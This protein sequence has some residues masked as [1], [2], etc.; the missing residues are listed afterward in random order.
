MQKCLVPIGINDEFAEIISVR[1]FEK[2][3]DYCTIFLG[4]SV[5][6]CKCI[7]SYITDK[8][9]LCKHVF[10][11]ERHPGYEIKYSA[12]DRSSSGYRLGES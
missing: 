11:A 8:K 2:E 3:D 9:L 12:E 10:L 4:V 7:C 6:M 1:L 5:S